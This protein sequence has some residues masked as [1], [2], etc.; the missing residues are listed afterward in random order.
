[1]DSRRLRPQGAQTRLPACPGSTEEQ[2]EAA[3]R[4]AKQARKQ[5]RVAEAAVKGVAVPKRLKRKQK[6]GVRIR[7]NLVVRV[8]RA[9]RGG[10]AAARQLGA[11]HSGV[12]SG[13]GAARSNNAGDAG[14]AGLPPS[15]DKALRP[16]GARGAPSVATAPLTPHYAKRS[17]LPPPPPQKP[18]T[19]HTPPSQGIKVTDAESK[20]RIKEL[21][22]AE[23]A[24]KDLMME[25]EGPAA[26]QQEQQAAHAA[27]Q[28]GQE[29]RQRRVGV[30]GGAKVKG[31]S[32]KVKAGKKEK[33]GK[34]AKAEGMALG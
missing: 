9:G 4:A 24:M 8:S 14:A 32:V 28:R 25:V 21:L 29:E 34:K 1:M 3:K 30:G 22:A 18:T 20:Q 27:R 16:G 19:H 17:R 31:S 33:K 12:A 2:E 13:A 11:L 6:K 7:K 23:E 26:E 10:G 15:A 5:A